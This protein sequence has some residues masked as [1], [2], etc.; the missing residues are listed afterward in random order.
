MSRRPPARSINVT[1]CFK[2]VWASS[3]FLAARA[4]RTFLMAVRI[5]ER[6]ELLAAVRLMLRRFCFSA[7]FVLANGDPL[8]NPYRRG[9]AR[10]GVGHL[11][12]RG[13]WGNGP[14]LSRAFSQ[15]QAA[16][17]QGNGYLQQFSAR[18]KNVAYSS[19]SS[20]GFFLLLDTPVFLPE[21][22]FDPLASSL[23]AALT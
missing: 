8:I 13:F 4:A 22:D 10:L 21:P 16:P 12:S 2:R 9:R 18:E 23:A 5:S 11:G 14:G 17:L 19:S 1:A 15:R 20:L 6:R 3:P 7:D